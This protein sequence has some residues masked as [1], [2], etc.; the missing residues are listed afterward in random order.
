MV[1]HVLSCRSRLPSTTPSHQHP[2]EPFPR[3]CDLVWERL[4]TFLLLS[5][6]VKHLGSELERRLRHVALR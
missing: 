2:D 1:M 3:R 4:P 6:G 5:S